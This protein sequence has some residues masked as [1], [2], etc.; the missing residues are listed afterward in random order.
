MVGKK[1]DALNTYLGFN[2]Q[3]DAEIPT[4]TGKAKVVRK[5]ST[6]DWRHWFTEDDV[7]H[8]KPAYTP[9]MEVIGYDCQDWTLS[10]EPVIEPEYSS[11][12]MQ[13]LAQRKSSKSKGS[14]TDRIKKLFTKG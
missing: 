1:Y 9:Y 3:E 10:P 12:Y 8:F 11:M 4:S 6:G 2:V 7:E 13:R 5:K 14:F